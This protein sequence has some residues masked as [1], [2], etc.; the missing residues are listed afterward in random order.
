MSHIHRLIIYNYRGIK[1]LD[2]DFGD[3]NLIILIGRG[4]SGKTTILNAIH[5]VLSPSWNMTFNDLDFHEQD[6]SKPIIIEAIVSGLPQEILKESKFGLYTLPLDDNDFNP[7]KLCLRIILTVTD[8]LEPH[9]CVRVDADGQIPDKPIS[10]SDRALLSVNLI[11]DYSDNQFAYNRQSPLY[12]L[13]KKSI[14]DGQSIEVVK[15]KLLRAINETA[16][17][18]ILHR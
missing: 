17:K 7:R 18:N 2:C 10:A 14:E 12:S 8:T 3:E 13:T 11:G 9:W 15:S 16:D 4:D 1:H 6:L 5:A